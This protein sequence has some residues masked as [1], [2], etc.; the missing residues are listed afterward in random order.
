MRRYLGPLV[1]LAALSGCSVGRD[2]EPSNVRTIPNLGSYTITA[3]GGLTA[4]CVETGGG[5]ANCTLRYRHR[6]I[7]CRHV[8]LADIEGLKDPHPEVSLIC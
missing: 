6:T 1:L 4:D 7:R 8:K 5:Y 3:P 2:D